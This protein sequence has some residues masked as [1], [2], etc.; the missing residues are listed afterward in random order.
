MAIIFRVNIPFDPKISNLF[1]HNK[2]NDELHAKQGK[3][4]NMLMTFTP[5]VPKRM[6]F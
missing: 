6:T 1:L 4:T 5:S 2:A 3:G